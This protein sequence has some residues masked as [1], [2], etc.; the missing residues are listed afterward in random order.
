MTLSDH[1]FSAWRMFGFTLTA[2]TVVLASGLVIQSSELAVDGWAFIGWQFICVMPLVGGVVAYVARR[3]WLAGRFT[4]HSIEP[5]GHILLPP[6]AVVVM[7]T[8][9]AYSGWTYDARFALSRDA[10]ERAVRSGETF[11]SHSSERWIG[12]YKVRS[13]EIDALGRTAFNLGDC[14]M[15]AHCELEFDAKTPCQLRGWR[16][17]WAIDTHWCVVVHDHL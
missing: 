6:L 11:E 12:L 1:E 10:F 8:L 14:S 3:V 15:F 17:Y 7:G 16:E 5:E 2:I 13:V 4:R 9:L